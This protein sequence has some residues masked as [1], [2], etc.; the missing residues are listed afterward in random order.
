MD[1]DCRRQYAVWV[2]GQMPH[3]NRAAGAQIS[4]LFIEPDAA[5]MPAHCCTLK[6]SPWFAKLI[7]TSPDV[8]GRRLPSD[9]STAGTGAVR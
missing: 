1:D 2:P 8:T 5:A 4:F 9:Y 3:S 6:I 7:L